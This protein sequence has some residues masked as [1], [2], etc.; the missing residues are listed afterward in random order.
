[1]FLAPP[2]MVRSQSSTGAPSGDIDPE[3][4][5]M[6]IGQ[7]FGM[8]RRFGAS[9]EMLGKVFE[10]MFNNFQNMSAKES[11]AAG[12]YIMN[13]SIV[14]Q[15]KVD[16]YNFTAEGEAQYYYPWGRYNL[17]NSPTYKNEYPYMKVNRTGYANISVTE[18]VAVTFIIWDSDGSLIAAIDRII[19]AFQELNEVSTSQA[20]DEQKMKKAASAVISALTYFIIHVNDI[21][22]GDEVLVLSMNAFTEYDVVYQGYA[23]TVTWHHT[24]NGQQNDSMLLDTTYPAWRTEYAA[25]SSLWNDNYMKWMLA[26][27]S[28]AGKEDASYTEFSFDVIQLWLKNF[29]VHI[30]VDALLQLLTAAQGA[31]DTGMGPTEDPLGGKAIE[32]VFE[33][34]DIE[35]YLL[36]HHFSGFILFNDTYFSDPSFGGN[37]SNTINNG[38]PDVVRST[39][40]VHEGADVELIVDSEVDSYMVFTGSDFSFIEPQIIGDK[41]TWGVET[42]ELE[43]RMIPMGLSPSEVNLTTAPKIE[44]DEFKLGFT[45]EVNRSEP[46]VT[47]DFSIEGPKEVRMDSASVKLLTTFGKWNDTSSLKGELGLATVFIST[48]LHVHL[49]IK[50]QD[51]ETTLAEDN[52]ALMDEN[53]YSEEDHKIRVGNHPDSAERLPLAAIDIAGPEYQQYDGTTVSNHAAKTTIIPHF[54]AE[55]NAKNSETYQDSNNETNVISSVLTVEFSTLIYAVAYPSFQS[56]GQKI[57][58]DPTFTIFI[59]FDNPMF[60]AVILVFGSVI[61][62]GVAAVMITKKKE[63]AIRG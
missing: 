35:F 33:G 13:A 19:S 44:M 37:F 40:G 28:V 5:G 60:W 41:I 6:A 61:L 16:E 48:I 31:V 10:L 46:V 42:E 4:M 1:M 12:V 20:S 14:T 62:V 29:E 3:M 58:H 55:L 25:K 53:N 24:V 30:D 8:F 7:I 52:Q 15:S 45:F 2:M 51:L 34:L 54:Y 17:K 57:E 32:D 50:N 22:N 43:F 9:G 27:Q 36:T 63:A 59:E 26:Q 38:V 21:I 56:T 23:E 11:S 49:N 18:G 39:I 47:E